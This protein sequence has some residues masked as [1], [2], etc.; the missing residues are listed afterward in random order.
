MAADDRVD[1]DAVSLIASL[2][3][4][5]AGAFDPVGFRFLEA[6]DRRAQAQCGGV[7]RTIEDRLATA[8]AE[9]SQRFARAACEAG[10]ALARG[11]ERFPHAADELKQ[12][13]EAGDFKGL[14]RQLA[15][16]EQPACSSPLA[17][18]LAHVAR[19]SSLDTPGAGGSA[20]SFGEPEA[21]LKA[22]RHFRSTWS[23]LSVDHQLSQAVAQAP[24]NAGPLN[25]H[26]LALQALQ[27]MR[28]ASA[29]CLA[30]YMSYFDA[31]SWLDRADS[32]RV[33]AQKSAGRG[34]RGR[35]T[36]RRD[37]S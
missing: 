24:A 20:A 25:S 32:G 26:F 23:R 9:F 4:R 3:A 30:G 22:L 10:A 29:E 12:R 31:L 5:G 33:Q 2:R 37:A 18:L 19:L 7:P 21:E 36:S 27:L 28:D 15:E 6:L 8:L 17:E 13:H 34:D 16:L 14:R 35:R 1:A 11:V